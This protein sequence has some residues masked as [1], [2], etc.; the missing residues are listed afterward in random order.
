MSSVTVQPPAPLSAE[1]VPEQYRR[2]RWDRL[3]DVELVA[4]IAGLVGVPKRDPADSFVLHAPLE[5]AARTALL[6]F[7]RPELR[8]TARLRI[9]ALGLRYQS[10]GSPVTDADPAAFVSVGEAAGYLLDAVRAGDLDAVDRSAAWLGRAATAGELRRELAGGFT[11]RLSAAAHAPIFLYLLPRVAPRG[12]LPGEL[13]RGLARE[14]ARNPDWALRWAE[15]R[16]A[17]QMATGSGV[18]PDD[19]EALWAAVAATPSGATDPGSTFIFPT[20]AAVDESGLAAELLDGVTRGPQVAA[21]G[22]ALLRAAAWSMLL[23]DGTHSPYGWT[24]CLTLPQ[25][26]MGT[27]EASPD[28]A[29]ALAVAATYVVGFRASLARRPLVADLPHDDPGVDVRAG[30]GA[31]LDESPPVAA[32]A[33]WYA[34]DRDLDEVMTSVAGRAATAHDA[35]L[36]KYTLAC[37]DAAA[38]DP[39]HRRLFL[40]AAASL[41]AW[42]SGAPVADDPLA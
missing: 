42:W 7:V 29:G 39:G 27:A 14:L 22:R 34:P 18:D 10:S 13:L 5:L 30:G 1:D 40:A 36:V 9:A 20:M 32:A 24:H 11:G 26:V 2:R 8:T 33:V 21:R 38:E 16:P 3:S 23:E 19:A 28:P 4:T 37:L 15:R 12:E 6:R 25:A 41:V 31:F 17:P 35:H